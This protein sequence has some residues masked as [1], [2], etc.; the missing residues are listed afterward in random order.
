MTLLALIFSIAVSMV[1]LIAKQCG[2]ALGGL[3]VAYLRKHGRSVM[4]L[5]CGA[6][7]CALLGFIVVDLTFK[8]FALPAFLV[9]ALVFLFLQH[10]V[11]GVRTWSKKEVIKLSFWFDGLR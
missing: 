8:Y 9:G 7:L 6:A 1:A 3:S 2:H 11:I 4:L 10:F 5:Y